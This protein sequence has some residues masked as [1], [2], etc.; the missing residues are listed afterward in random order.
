MAREKVYEI[1]RHPG[2]FVADTQHLSTLEIGAYQL[3]CDNIVILGQDFEPASLPD[4]DRMLANIAHLT[5]A[6]W[7]KMRPRLCEG[8]LAVLTVAG[9][10][11]S[12]ARVEDEIEKA[13]VRIRRAIKGGNASGE[14]RRRKRDLLAEKM[15]NSARTQVELQ[16]NLSSTTVQTP[17][18]EPAN[19]SSTQGA[20]RGELDANLG[21]TT[22]DTRHTTHEKK[23][24]PASQ[25]G[26]GSGSRGR[27]RE[28][29]QRTHEKPAVTPEGPDAIEFVRKMLTLLVPKFEPFS[30]I[31]M[32]LLMRDFGEYFANPYL[33]AAIAANNHAQLYK[34]P[35]FNYFKTIVKRLHA[36]GWTFEEETGGQN[37]RDYV[38]GS[39]LP[40]L[41]RRP[42]DDR[43][44]AKP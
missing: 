27:A 19:L 25:H 5:L 26:N 39:V 35:R 24:T 3:I 16:T 44:E 40:G 43:L 20:T 36:E 41:E 15:A 4:D 31:D 11:V 1:N 42:M 32:A 2:N 28:E 18:S 38:L 14:S 9:G 37:P 10:R 6:E 8:A 22:H 13:R 17:L 12:Q 29:P 7:R 23:K 30:D 34:S 21:R 33:L